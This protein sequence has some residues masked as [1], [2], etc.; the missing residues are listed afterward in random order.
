[1]TLYIKISILILERVLYP[2]QIGIWSDDDNEYA[3]LHTVSISL[4]SCV[5]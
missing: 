4:T 2:V 1:M 5:F 3:H